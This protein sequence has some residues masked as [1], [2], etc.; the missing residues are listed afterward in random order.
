MTGED[1]DMDEL[2]KQLKGTTLKVYYTLLR[3]NSL[4]SLREIQRK[5]RL[6]SPSLALHHLDKLKRLG[7]VES[8][9]HGGY[10]VTHEVRVGILRFFFG[11]G[12]LMVPRYAFYFVFFGFELIGYLLFVGW[13]FNPS[14]ILLLITLLS[15]C[16][17]TL[18]ETAM[19]WHSQP[20]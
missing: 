18:Y 2:D 14:D 1:F 9:P 17:I 3:E 15:I 20:S 19:M 13:K 12:R 11:K 6:S 10:S 8:N 5:A 4:M 16:T 7:L